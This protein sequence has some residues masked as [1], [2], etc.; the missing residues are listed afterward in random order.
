MNNELKEVLIK[1]FIAMIFYAAVVAFIFFCCAGRT[2]IPRAWIFFIVNLFYYLVPIVVLFKLNPELLIHRMKRKK[3][4]KLWDKI[5]VRIFLLIGIYGVVIVAG[6]DIGRYNWSYLGLSYAVV[7]Y[8]LYLFS[9]IVTVWTM[10][11]NRHFEPMVRIQKDR[12]HKVVRDGP[13][14][15]IRHPGYFGMFFWL[16]SVPLILGSLYAFIPTLVAIVLLILRT[17][18]EDKTLRKELSGYKEYAHEVRYRL[19]PGIW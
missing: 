15:Y 5:L 16:L 4:A 1:A 14:K 10:A 19:M 6:F 18:L 7:G 9:G 2:D 13:Y 8:I 12:G 17:L 11:V 3:D